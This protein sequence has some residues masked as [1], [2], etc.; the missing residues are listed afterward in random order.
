MRTSSFG[1]LDEFYPVPQGKRYRDVALILPLLCPQRMDPVAGLFRWRLYGSAAAIDS[2]G[3]FWSNNNW[4]V[5]SQTTIY[6]QF[7]GGT[8]SSRPTVSRCRQ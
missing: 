5:G 3:N 1:L 2:E 7:G 4:L 6:Q 8:E